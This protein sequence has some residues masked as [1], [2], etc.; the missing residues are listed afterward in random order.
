MKYFCKNCGK[1]N[2]YQTDPISYCGYCGIKFFSKN[3]NVKINA[4]TDEKYLDSDNDSRENV[5]FGEVKPKFD[6]KI[7]KDHS[8]SLGEL[9]SGDDPPQGSALL[10]ATASS[11]KEIVT[12]Q[13]T[14]E[15][16]L[17]EFANESSSLRGTQDL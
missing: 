10:N 11:N 17:K 5:K 13:K 2:F 12:Q 1:S 16:I 6:L 7:Y 15:D 8:F 9:V 3:E 14:R 4:N